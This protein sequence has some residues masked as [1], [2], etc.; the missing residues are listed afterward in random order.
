MEKKAIFTLIRVVIILICSIFLVNCKDKDKK[1]DRRLQENLEIA[2]KEFLKLGGVQI[3]ILRDCYK[4]IN[5]DYSHQK[6]QVILDSAMMEYFIHK[7][8]GKNPIALLHTEIHTRT[9]SNFIFSKGS[10]TD[11]DFSKKSINGTLLYEDKKVIYTEFSESDVRDIKPVT[12]DSVTYTRIL[13]VRIIGNKKEDDR[14]S[15]FFFYVYY[16]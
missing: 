12:I 16:P 8:W 10:L 14:I 6:N 13:G 5:D 9:D 2:D 1:S 15:K 3:S 11:Y 7:R 4:L